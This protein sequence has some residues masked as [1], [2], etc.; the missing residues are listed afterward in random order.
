MRCCSR[1]T[2]N[3]DPHAYS[4]DGKTFSTRA[5]DPPT[6]AETDELIYDLPGRCGEV[7]SHGHHVRIVKTA[8]RPAS[9]ALLVRHGGGDE[10]LSLP[11]RGDAVVAPLADL[12][13]NARYWFVLQVYNLAREHGRRM[14]DAADR[15]W[16]DA[17]AERRIIVRK[18]R[19][20]NFYDVTIRPAA[21]TG[22]C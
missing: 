21:V 15:R 17:A 16:R 8:G 12:A 9:C 3:G 14:A 6:L 11:Y 20:R 2:I 5:V 18:R 19:G 13:A 1:P 4:W 10:R 22:G 7:D